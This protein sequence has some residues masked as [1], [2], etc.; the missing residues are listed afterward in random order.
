M[1]LLDS[2]QIPNYVSAFYA[3]THGTDQVATEASRAC[4]QIVGQLGSGL[5][6][7][8]V[9]DHTPALREQITTFMEW[10]FA[11]GGVIEFEGL[12]W[13][14]RVN[15]YSVTFLRH[16]LADETQ[17]QHL[18]INQ[19]TFWP[20]EWDCAEINDLYATVCLPS[21]S[22]RMQQDVAGLLA[23]AGYVPLA[24]AIASNNFPEVL[25]TQEIIASH[26]AGS[27]IA[28]VPTDQLVWF[29][30]D[31]LASNMVPIWTAVQGKSTKEEVIAY[32][33]EA[34]ARL[35]EGYS[36]ATL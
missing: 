2:K 33:N 22:W 1:A 21:G 36:N 30:E 27:I 8:Q 16:E 11:E 5:S 3:E 12:E 18:L 10:L 31:G 4:G 13:A 19:S 7:K 26:I 29:Q 20:L 9:Y 32:Y 23:R 17:W 28:G 6:L 15:D 14:Y 25:S 34:L 24:Q 35:T